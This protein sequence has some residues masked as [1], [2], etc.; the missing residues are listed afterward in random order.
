MGN[1]VHSRQVSSVT[2]DEAMLIDEVL[3]R[4]D[5]L[6]STLTAGIPLTFDV[7]SMSGPASGDRLTHGERLALEAVAQAIQ[8]SG[9]PIHRITD[10]EFEIAMQ[11]AAVIRRFVLVNGASTDADDA[12]DNG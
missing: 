1:T 6:E 3:G 5:V 8:S 10:E 2:T 9:A 4:I 12:T 11:R 7:E